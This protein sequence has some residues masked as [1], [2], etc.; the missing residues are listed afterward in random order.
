MRVIK[1]AYEKRT[2][3]SASVLDEPI[4]NWQALPCI[5]THSPNER[6]GA[7]FTVAEPEPQQLKEM[8]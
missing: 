8:E 1:A 2:S 7:Q 5:L 3:G 4:Y 6:C